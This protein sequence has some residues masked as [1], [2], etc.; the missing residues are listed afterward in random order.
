MTRGEIGESHGCGNENS[1]E[2][3]DDNCLDWLVVQKGCIFFGQVLEFN[4]ER[5]SGSDVNSFVS[6]GPIRVI[7]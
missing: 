4:I 7:E 1:R 6:V 2:L 5:K 3:H